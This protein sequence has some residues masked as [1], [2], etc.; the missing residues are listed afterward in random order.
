VCLDFGVSH[1]FLRLKYNYPE[2]GCW[3]RN[4]DEMA[5]RLNALG[6]RI[7]LVPEEF[8][9]LLNLILFGWKAS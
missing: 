5:V 8:M 2:I 1:S 9:N 7:M 6:A 3:N 4:W